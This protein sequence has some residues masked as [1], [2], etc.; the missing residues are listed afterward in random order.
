MIGRICDDCG[1]VIFKGFTDD[2]GSFYNC[3]ECFNKTDYTAVD[4]DGYGGFYL[5][6]YGEATGIYYTEWYVEDEFCCELQFE[7]YAA[8][9]ELC[10]ALEIELNGWLTREEIDMI[11]KLGKKIMERVVE[12]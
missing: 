7:V 1:K 2:D 6:A 10:Q 5:D 11:N 3:E 12:K 4:D 9:K 8:T